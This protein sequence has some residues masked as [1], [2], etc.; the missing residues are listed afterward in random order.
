LSSSN[1]KNINLIIDKNLTISGVGAGIFTTSSS[2]GSAGGIN[3]APSTSSNNL[4]IGLTDAAAI[5]S[6]SSG[7]RGAGNIRIKSRSLSLDQSSISSEASRSFGGNLD[8]AI[9]NV[10]LMRN[11]SSISSSSGSNNPSSS[12][13]NINI[14]SAFIVAPPFENNDIKANGFDGKGGA[15]TIKTDKAFGIKPRSR[16]ELTRLLNST[17]SLDPIRLDTSEITAISQ[18]NPTLSGPVAFTELNVDPVKGLDGEP[19]TPSAP[20]VSEDCSTQPQSQGS[21]II[22]SGQGGIT[23]MPTDSLAPSNIWQ[24]TSTRPIQ[25]ISPPE[26]ILPIAQGWSRKDNQTVILTGQTTPKFPTVACHAN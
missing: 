20:S 23:P 16:D 6:K 26:N 9:D 8:L 4:K 15:V 18:N 3:I 5:T 12:S 22:N 10:L 14:T 21:R 17:T 25:G 2:T 1:A 19:L 7:S 24:E 13:G 11:Q